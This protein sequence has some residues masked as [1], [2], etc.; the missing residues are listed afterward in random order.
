MG[1]DACESWIIGRV[2]VLFV[3]DV[4][5]VRV[6]FISLATSEVYH[7][8]KRAVIVQTHQEVVWTDISIDVAVI[9]KHLKS[10]QDL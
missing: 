1:I 4:L 2:Y 7:E 3:V 10:V 5:P 9:M 6:P 8:D